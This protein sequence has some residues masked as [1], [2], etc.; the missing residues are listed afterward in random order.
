MLW[1][2][3]PV[4]CTSKLLKSHFTALHI[5][6]RNISI[7]IFSMPGCP[8]RISSQPQPLPPRTIVNNRLSGSVGAIGVLRERAQAPTDPCRPSP[9]GAQAQC[10]STGNRA[11]SLKFLTDDLKWI[12]IPHRSA[13]A[14]QATRVTPTLAAPRTHATHRHAEKTASVRETVRD[15]QM[16]KFWP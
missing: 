11:V 16:T 9:C 2:E 1:W 8:I 13:A 12:I 10:R 4:P 15:Q 14:P 3:P 7:I 6:T 5:Y